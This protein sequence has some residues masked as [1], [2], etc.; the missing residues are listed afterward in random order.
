MFYLIIAIM[1]LL[2]YIFA[3]PDNV[4]GTMNLVAFVFFLVALLI[5]L[6]L[7]FLTVTQSPPEIWVGIAM[8]IVGLWAMCDIYL[9]DKKGVKQHK[10]NQKK[11][12]YKYRYR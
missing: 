4:K 8:S 9:M 7:G 11:R 2:F 3:A 1:L 12:P 5:A 6:A 10:Q